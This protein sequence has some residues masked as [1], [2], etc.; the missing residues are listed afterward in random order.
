MTPAMKAVRVAK[1]AKAA[2]AATSHRTTLPADVEQG[3]DNPVT[4]LIS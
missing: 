4:C 1:E 3:E 2:K